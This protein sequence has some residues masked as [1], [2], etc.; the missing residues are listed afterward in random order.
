MYNEVDESRNI[1]LRERSQIQ[2][3]VYGPIPFLRHSRKGTNYSDGRKM[4]AWGESIE[5][6]G[7]EEMPLGDEHVL[8]TLIVVSVMEVRAFI[9]TD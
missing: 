4:G 3:N 6:K 5:Y 7:H 9:K 2:N 8:C 1:M